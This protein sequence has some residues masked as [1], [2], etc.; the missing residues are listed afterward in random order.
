MT[1]LCKIT[2][3]NQTIDIA[4]VSIL[5]VH[6]L[7]PI[8]LCLISALLIFLMLFAETLAAQIESG[9]NAP[10]RRSGGAVNPLWLLR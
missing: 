4:R 10:R 6:M 8:R 2:R 1:S 9:Q 5:S 7:Q 3:F